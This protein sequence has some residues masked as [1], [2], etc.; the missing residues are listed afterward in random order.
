M[1][2]AIK[3]VVADIDGTLVPKGG[4]LMPKTVEAFEKLHQQGVLIGLASG[5][6]IDWRMEKNAEKWGLSFSF[7]FLIGMNGGELKDRFHEGIAEFYK[8]KKETIKDL[9][10]T[11]K[12]LLDSKVLFN[13]RVYEGDGMCCLHEDELMHL[14]SERNDS[15]LIDAHDDIYRLAKNDTF[16]V[17][18]F[19]KP[20]DA[21]IV[22][23]FLAEHQDERWYGFNTFPG[24]LEICDPHINKGV[25]LKEFSRRNNID[26]KDIIAFGDMDNDNAL[27]E[28]AGLGVAVKNAGEGTK[29]IAD[30]VA[31]YG[32][33]EDAVGRYLFDHD[34]IN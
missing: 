12:P 11:V 1:T 18:F 23:K 27:L 20:E 4:N 22:D 7:D 15:F 19:Y 13:A 3:A 5:R 24:S 17:M 14:S 29:A 21:A 30:D 33:D 31:E 16:K 6:P 34:Y 32:V 2:K 10:E 28:N 8:M 25:A 26:L 9:M